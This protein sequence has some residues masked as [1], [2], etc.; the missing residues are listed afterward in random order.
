V[1]S[2]LINGGGGAFGFVLARALLRAGFEQ[3][4]SARLARPNI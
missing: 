3:Q 1:K 2:A 4:I